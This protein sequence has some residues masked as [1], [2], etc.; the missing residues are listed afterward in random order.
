MKT[1]L[2]IGVATLIGVATF[3]LIESLASAQQTDDCDLEIALV[4][5]ILADPVIAAGDPTMLADATG[6][7]DQAIAECNGT[8]SGR[9][10]ALALLAQAKTLLGH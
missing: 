3:L 8:E 5:D 4:E 2:T 7:L 6:L 9:V 1:K 10:A